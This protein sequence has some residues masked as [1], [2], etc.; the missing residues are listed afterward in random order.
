M[1]CHKD[2]GSDDWDWIRMHY[3]R[4]HYHMTTFVFSTQR[5]IHRLRVILIGFMQLFGIQCTST[6]SHTYIYCQCWILSQVMHA[7]MII[8]VL[9][10]VILDRVLSSTT[11]SIRDV[12]H[13]N[14]DNRI[15]HL[16]SRYIYS[17]QCVLTPLILTRLRLNMEPESVS[18]A[19][20]NGVGANTKNDSVGT[21]RSRSRPNTHCLHRSIITMC[22]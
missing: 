8:V 16:F 18:K 10:L 2:R 17:S 19:Q 21:K 4:W 9:L 15:A 11:A 6:Y 13:Y 14:I 5:I 1:K 22:L 3:S 7:T 12:N 20:P